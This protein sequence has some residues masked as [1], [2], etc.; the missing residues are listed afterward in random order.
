M[1]ENGLRAM[2]FTAGGYLRDGLHLNDIQPALTDSAY[3]KKGDLFLSLRHKSLIIQY[4]PSTGKI[5]WMKQGPWL[6]QHDVDILDDH[7]IAVFNN[8]AYE[9]GKGWWIDGASEVTV[10]DFAT[11]TATNPYHDTLLAENVTSLTE[12]LFDMTSSGHVVIEEENRG[13]ILILDPAGKLVA[14]YVNRA[15]DGQVYGLGW[16]RWIT[17]AE[18]DAALTAIAAGTPCQQ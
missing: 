14:S 12:G 4:R 1:E 8:N 6:A 3:W 16:S 18:G 2:L 13:R 17:R 5:I 15:P 10:Y 9:R 7:R 11:D